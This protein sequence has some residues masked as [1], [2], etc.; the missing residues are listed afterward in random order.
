MAFRRSEIDRILAELSGL[1]A[2]SISQGERSGFLNQATELYRPLREKK[3]AS[4]GAR[5]GEIGQSFADLETRLREGAVGE[6]KGFEED[7]NRL[8]LLQSGK[9]AAGIG[10]IRG[11]LTRDLGSAAIQRAVA[12]ADLALEQAGFE[13]D[14]AR[15]IEDRA[16]SFANELLQQRQTELGLRSGSLQAQLDTL[17]KIA[18]LEDARAARGAAASQNAALAALAK[19]IQGATTGAAGGKPAV[20]PESMQSLA[21]ASTRDLVQFF[22]SQGF[23]PQQVNQLSTAIMA[24]RSGDN[25]VPTDERAKSALTEIYQLMGIDPAALNQPSAGRRRNDLF[26]NFQSR[27]GRFDIRNIPS[28]TRRY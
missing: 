16:T 17:M 14:L 2:P 7:T 3:L 19:K 27:A 24:L 21:N 4:F 6:Q 23:N 12:E 28:T 9:T 10:K 25:Y 11:N 1:Q 13:T 18:Q 5:R 8:G 15:Q 26:P 22:K 20:S